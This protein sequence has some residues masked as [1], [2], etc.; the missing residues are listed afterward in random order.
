MRRIHW[1]LIGSALVLGGCASDTQPNDDAGPGSCPAG[2]F[3]V[4]GKCAALT[5]TWTRIKT[6]GETTCGRG[7]PYSFF[8]HPGTVDKVL[9][10][11]AFGGFCYNA[12]LCRVGAPN[13][14]PE[15]NVDEAA[16]ATTPG[17]FDLSNPKNPFKD[18]NIVYVPECTADF[19]W[20][21]SVQD[22]PALNGSPAI[23]IKHKGFVNVTAV[24][25]WI[26]KSFANPERIFVSGSS[27]GGDAAQ[28]HYTYL[29]DHYK[30]VKNW[31]LFMD[32]SFG[33]TT[34]EAQMTYTTNWG[35]YP[36]RPTFI[37]AI[38]NAAPGDLNWDFSIVAGDKYF[39]DGITAEFGTSY[40]TLESFTYAIHGGNMDDWHDKAMAS[41][42]N[43]SKQ[44]TRFRYYVAS[45]TAH[46]ILNQPSYY[47]YEENGVRLN[48]WVTDLANGKAVENNMCTKNCMVT[49]LQ[50][51]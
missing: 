9:I 32:S 48:D 51:N 29:R 35:V 4:D 42:A 47:Q 44:T 39:P 45:G 24:R 36:N 43:I 14:V 26:Y 30:D 40:D 33:V 5:G 22:Y 49:H 8:V 46:I 38:K 10:Y 17:I 6:G 3:L 41:L 12:D 19:E 2:K 50:S 7:A 20:G 21:N 1:L 11:F 28:M 34:P 37:P 15:V 27:G 18:W 25:E 16:L 31:V 13:F 23:T